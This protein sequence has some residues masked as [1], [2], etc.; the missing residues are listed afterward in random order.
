MAQFAQRPLLGLQVLL[1]SIIDASFSALAEVMPN[2]REQH[3]RGPWVDT[4]LSHSPASGSCAAIASRPLPR[5][6]ASVLATLRSFTPPVAVVSILRLNVGNQRASEDY[7]LGG[8]G[9]CS[10]D[11]PAIRACAFVSASAPGQLAVL[12]SSQVRSSA[13]LTLEPH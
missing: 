3:Y 9:R 1:N 13:A 6:D 11:C 2:G 8:L 12:W 4:A 10:R 5:T 7:R